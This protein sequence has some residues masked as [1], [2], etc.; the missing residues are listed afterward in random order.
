MRSP[1]PT[2]W[3]PRLGVAGIGLIVLALAGVGAVTVARWMIRQLSSPAPAT[4]TIRVPPG[5]AIAS[6][7]EPRDIH[8]PTA[9]L[10]GP[11]ENLYLLT[12]EGDI[13]QFE[14]KDGNTDAEA[15]RQVFDGSEHKVTHAV[16][17]AFHDGKLYLSDS[18]R[19][20]VL[21]DD[22]GDGDYDTLTPVVTGLVS[23]RYPDHSNNGI[24][25]GPDG[26]LYVGVGSTTDH[27]PI[28]D[29][30]EASVLR[31]NADGSDLQVFAAGFRNPYDLT[32]SPEGD[33]FTADN[34]PSKFDRTLR[35][36]VPE[37]LNL[38]QQGRHYG[39]PDVYG[40]PP[41]GA[42]SAAPITEF[43]PSVG[44]A[45]LIYYAGRQFPEAYQNAVYVAL[46]GT[47]AQVA[48]D[49]QITN[50]QMVVV[51]PLRRGDD[52]ALHGEWEPFARFNT[53]TNFRPID[54]TVGPD[55]ALYILEWQTGAVYRVAYVGETV[56]AES[57]TA[58]A[59][60]LPAFSPEQ[61]AA[62]E[63]LYRNGAAGAPPCLTCH[64]LDDRAG[65]GPSLV[66]LR[67]VAHQRVQGLSAVEYVRQSILRPNDYIVP[68]YNSDYMYQNYGDVLTE[69]EIESLIAFVFSL[70]K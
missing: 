34:N 52:G 14:D 1:I 25:F 15:M 48:L 53:G 44:S 55:E 65:L 22:D 29:P 40:K 30:M 50:G 59:E 42:T 45:G 54:V 4:N 21:S 43:Y 47:G 37:E 31:L 46:W 56:T 57:A 67:D 9:I 62:G 64:L 35:S 66:G 36:L 51:V 33:L 32:F 6:F 58:T 3:W 17:L 69:A 7:A 60:P 16:G 49:R 18:G 27:G 28:T 11:D 13:F 10:F 2:R 38:V 19:I 63:A 70:S 68:N 8:L 20:S 61:V 24:A 12:L 41:L 23:L 39:F 26:K 5:F